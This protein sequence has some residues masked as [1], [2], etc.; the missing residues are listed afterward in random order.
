MLTRDLRIHDNPM[1]VAAVASQLPVVPLF[2]DDETILRGRPR[3]PERDAHLEAALA[4]LDRSLRRLGARL[5][6]RRGDWPTEVLRMAASTG[7][8]TVHVMQDVTPYAKARLARLRKGAGRN[9]IVETH[10]AGTVIPPGAVAPAGSDHYRVFTPYHRRWSA[11]PWRPIHPAPRRVI[12]VPGVSDAASGPGPTASGQGGEHAARRQLAAWIADGVATYPKTRDRLDNP[13]GSSRLSTDLHFGCLSPLEV[14]T[15]ALPHDGAAP[16][17]RQLCWRDF[18]VQAVA[19]RPEVVWQN[20]VDRPWS[21]RSTRTH[22][23]AWREGRTGYPLVDA[24]MRQLA[25]EG[26]LP[27]RARMVVASFL[28][29]DLGLDWREGARHFLELL[30]DADVVVNNLNWQWT[31]GTGTGSHPGRALSPVRQGRRFDPEGAYVR[32]FVPELADVPAS[33]IHDPTPEDRRRRG[34][35]APIVGRFR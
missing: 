35:P 7:A 27:N 8:K 6:R 22:L 28:A 29:K 21:P 9:V 25:A 15:R 2:V 17:V 16:F 3:R 13:G 20:F 14:A 18:Y 1:L 11:T 5:V 32:R 26:F 12:P 31:A 33:R 10:G 4:D 24:G 34:Y 30:V 19:A 23:D